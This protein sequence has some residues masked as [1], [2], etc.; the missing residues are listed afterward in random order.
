MEES[1]AGNMLIIGTDMAETVIN[2]LLFMTL[3]T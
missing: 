1:L 3:T 2:F